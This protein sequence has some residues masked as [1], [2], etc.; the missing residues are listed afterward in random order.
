MKLAFHLL[1]IFALFYYA[2]A[3]DVVDDFVAWTTTSDQALE[4]L[5]DTCGKDD[6]TKTPQQICTEASQISGNTPSSPSADWQPMCDALGTYT[7][8]VTDSAAVTKFDECCSACHTPAQRQR[9]GNDKPRNKCCGDCITDSQDSVDKLIVWIQM[10]DN[11]PGL[12][13][14]CAGKKDEKPVDL[15]TP[16][17]QAAGCS[18]FSP[19]DT[20]DAMCKAFDDVYDCNK[21]SKDALPDFVTCC[22]GCQRAASLEVGAEDTVREKCCQDCASTNKPATV[23]ATTAKPGPTAPGP[24]PTTAKPP[25]PGPAPTSDTTT[26]ESTSTEESGSDDSAFPL[27]PSGFLV[28]LITAMAVVNIA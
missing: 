2:K 8:T 21:A 17:Q 18:T 6:N 28:T 25:A 27:G 19:T 12:S 15:K 10:P 11:A 16:C 4:G 7:C 24:A 3:A 23:P 20:C 9:R 14:T 13:Q 5:T 1:S 22:S 26:M